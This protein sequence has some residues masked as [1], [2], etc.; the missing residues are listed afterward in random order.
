VEA[1]VP[2]TEI[3]V[4]PDNAAPVIVIT[5]PAHALAGIEVIEGFIAIVMV[6]FTLLV[7][8]QLVE[9]TIT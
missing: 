5:L 6:R 1:L 3:A 8:H 9:S 4:T 2:L 7:V